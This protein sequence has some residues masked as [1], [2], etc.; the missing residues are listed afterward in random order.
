MSSFA[1]QPADPE[2]KFIN[3]VTQRYADLILK[4]NELLI[5]SNQ[6][7][8]DWKTEP[9]R[10]CL[11]ETGNIHSQA[12][13]IWETIQGLATELNTVENPDVRLQIERVIEIAERIKNEGPELAKHIKRNEE[14]R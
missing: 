7:M 6:N 10:K 11:A 8:E 4:L 13:E 14:I 2:P 9:H 1:T 12:W 5:K 3:D